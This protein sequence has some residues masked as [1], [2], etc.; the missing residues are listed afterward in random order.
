MC[1]CSDSPARQQIG[2]GFRLAAGEKSELLRGRLAAEDRVAVREAPKALDDIDIGQP[3]PPV[4]TVLRIAPTRQAGDQRS[5]ALLVGG[6]L[7]GVERPG[8]E[9]WPRR[10]PPPIRAG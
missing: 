4:L 6:G 1:R 2:S 7:A 10:A 9:Q 8:G 5:R 3:I